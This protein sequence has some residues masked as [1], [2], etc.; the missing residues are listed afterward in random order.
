MPRATLGTAMGV[1]SSMQMLGVGICNLFVGV[2]LGSTED[3]TIPVSHWQ[4]VMVFM[5]MNNILCFICIVVLNYVDWKRNGILQK[6]STKVSM[7]RD[8]Y[9]PLD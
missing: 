8:I 3:S 2:I 1:A 7:E 5:L 6:T 9:E 4:N